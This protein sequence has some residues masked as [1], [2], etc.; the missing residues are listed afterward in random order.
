MPSPSDH[1]LVVGSGPSSVRWPTPRHPDGSPWRVATCN[2]ARKLHQ[3]PDLFGCFEINAGQKLQSQL[4]PEG[5]LATSGHPQVVALRPFVAKMLDLSATNGIMVVDQNFG[6]EELRDLHE[7]VEW[8]SQSPWGA[9]PEGVPDYGQ[10]RCWISSGVLM[11]WL[12]AE[13]YRPKVIAVAGLDG[14]PKTPDRIDQNGKPRFPDYPGLL[15]DLA[16]TRTPWDT[17]TLE[18]AYRREQMN[19]R[20]AL[21]IERLTNHYRDTEFVWLEPANH[22]TSGWRT[23]LASESGTLARLYQG[24]LQD[25]DP[26]L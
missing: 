6:P 13:L 3:K 4:K 9:L 19:V 5:R 2:S 11:L 10:R 24:Y 22:R 25:T 23:T 8:G 26:A 7:D 12:V 17:N 15:P 14:Y 1:W 18:A 16:T 21:G 20:M